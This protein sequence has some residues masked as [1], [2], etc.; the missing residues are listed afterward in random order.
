MSNPTLEM[1]RA[2]WTAGLAT[3][4]AD[5][6]SKG[7][8]TETYFAKLEGIVED[9]KAHLRR[10]DLLKPQEFTVKHGE[11]AVVVTVDFSGI[12]VVRD[13]QDPERPFFH[14]PAKEA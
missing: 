12:A 5:R 1:V 7:F 8:S 4:N 3:V 2:M 13:P 14:I 10:H 11:N 6:A 9:I